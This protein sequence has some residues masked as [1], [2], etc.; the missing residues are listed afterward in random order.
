MMFNERLK[1]L[2]LNSELTQK[3][4]AHITGVSI[5]AFQRYEHGD[6]EPNIKTLICLADF[7]NVTLDYFVGRTDNAEPF[8]KSETNLQAY[9][10]V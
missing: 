9:P 3:D 8:V 1:E 7:F 10:N 5:R 2:R 4:I 6:T